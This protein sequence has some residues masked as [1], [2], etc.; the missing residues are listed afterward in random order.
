MQPTRWQNERHEKHCGRTLPSGTTE[1]TESHRL[2][3]TITNQ[4]HA[5]VDRE[6]LIE[7]AQRYAL[8]YELNL[9]VRIYADGSTEITSE[10]DHGVENAFRVPVN[11]FVEDHHTDTVRIQE[12]LYEDED[13]FQMAKGVWADAIGLRDRILPRFTGV[14]CVGEVIVE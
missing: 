2:L 9:A 8:N 3:N 6:E 7:A 12:L 5:V 1:I 13:E 4:R 11:A 10:D 14:P